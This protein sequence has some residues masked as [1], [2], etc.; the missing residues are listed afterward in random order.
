MRFTPPDGPRWA[1]AA[2]A[3]RVV[4]FGVTG[5]LLWAFLIGLAILL[6]SIP[7]LLA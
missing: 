2:A 1:L 4:F 3:C 5:G 6:E 7:R